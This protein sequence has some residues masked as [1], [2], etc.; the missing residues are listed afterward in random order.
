M[1]SETPSDSFG[2]L[3]RWVASELLQLSSAEELVQTYAVL[4]RSR[5][6][7][8]E[9]GEADG[10]LAEA[11]LRGGA[12]LVLQ[13]RDASLQRGERVKPRVK[14][15]VPKPKGV[16]STPFELLGGRISGTLCGSYTF[17]DE[18]F[19]RAGMLLLV[20]EPTAAGDAVLEAL[21]SQVHSPPISPHIS[22]H[23]EALPSQVQSPPISPHI[24]PHFP[25]SR[26]ATLVG[27]ISHELP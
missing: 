21:P 7:P 3:L 15:H 14:K 4:D 18:A 16:P 5:F 2:V 19:K 11:G 20:V 24:S 23:L 6:P 17:A 10:T 1:A 9:V 13:R 12:T 27:A 26:G 22:P 8:L 25:L